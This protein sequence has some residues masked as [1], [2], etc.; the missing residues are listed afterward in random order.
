M[1]KKIAEK[2]ETLAVEAAE[3]TAHTAA[4][5]DDPVALQTEWTPAKGG[6]TNFRTH[7]MVRVNAGRMEFRPTKGAVA[8]SMIFLLV[9]LGLVGGIGFAKLSSGTLDTET[10]IPMGI[11]LVFALVGGALLHFAVKPIVFDKRNEY[12]WKGRKAP[13]A[14]FD[15]NAIKH[16]AELDDIH[17]LQIVSEYV[18]GDK[19]SYHSYELNLVLRDGRRINVVD[20]GNI[21]RLR[22][23]AATLAAFLDRPVWDAA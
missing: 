3:A 14:V 20:H 21:A 23:D 18:R 2:L 7:R 8:F 4:Q 19:S 17:A 10:L 15:K 11:G 1:F 13:D 5:F 22:E 9:G 12:F 16:W 6:G